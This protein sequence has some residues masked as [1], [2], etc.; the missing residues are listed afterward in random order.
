M[1]ISQ[2]RYF[3]RLA[4]V[5]HYTKAAQ[6]LFI[7]QP[8][9]SN[10]ISAL[11]S[12]LDVKFFLKH[13]RAIE[14]TPI[15]QEFYAYVCHALEILEEGL[16]TVKQYNNALGGTIRIAT[17]PTI[18]ADYLPKLIEEFSA[19]EAP[20]VEFNIVSRF[21]FDAISLLKQGQYDVIFCASEEDEELLHFVPVLDQPLVAVVHKSHPLAGS[22]KVLLEDLAPYHVETYHRKHKM[23]SQIFQLAR[24]NGI[25]YSS[26][27]DDEMII[28][29]ILRQRPSHVA[30]LLNTPFIQQFNDLDILELP[31]V[32]PDF[33]LISMAFLKNAERNKVTQSFI[34][35]VASHYSYSLDEKSLR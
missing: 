13:G 8:S 10:A 20:N 17:I 28:C 32:P 16:D 26:Q 22:G 2:L 12:E 31:Q 6:D 5:Q 34:D 23:S 3:K 29:G 7:T 19:R 35:F 24:K 30:L 11:E 1:N 33:H 21:S 15:G 25:T 9:L 27:F 14:L 18:Q 4:E